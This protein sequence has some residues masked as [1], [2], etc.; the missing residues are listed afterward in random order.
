VHIYGP[1]SG[2]SGYRLAPPEYSGRQKKHLPLMN[3]HSASFIA[4]YYYLVASHW[5]RSLQLMCR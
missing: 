4:P 3:Y 2:P 1:C 5:V